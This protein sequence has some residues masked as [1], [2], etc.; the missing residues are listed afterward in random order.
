MLHL[1]QIKEKEQKL[2]EAIEIYQQTLPIDRANSKVYEYL[3]W[4]KF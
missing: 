3:G 4:A 2:E 1:G